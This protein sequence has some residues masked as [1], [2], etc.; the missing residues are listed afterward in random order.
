MTASFPTSVPTVAE[1]KVLVNNLATLLDGAIN[2]A[3]VTI[4]VDDTTGFPTSGYFTIDSEVIYYAGKGATSF[5]SCVRGRDGTAPASHSNNAVVNQFYVADHHNHMAEELI[6][7]CQNLSDRIGLHATRIILQDY[8]NANTKKI[9]SLAAG[10][11]NGDAVRYEQV[12]LLIGGTVT[13]ATIF[14]SATGNP[15]HGTNTNDSASA[16]YI[17]EYVESVVGTTNFPASA[18]AG[19]LTS[20]S[21]SAGDWDVTVCV[22]VTGYNG[23]SFVE[24]GVST[25]SGDSLAGTTAGTDIAVS[26]PAGNYLTTGVSNYRVKISTTTTHYLK[27]Y[28]SYTGS[29]PTAQ[30]IISARRVR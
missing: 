3:V 23:L 19:D 27:Y 10:T 5:T 25:T 12:L 28:A 16:G 6:A 9:S 7:T 2:D 20:V 22:Y 18:I 24:I 17:G 14:S 11:T 4:T 15:I 8:L 29:T 26:G 13:G 21:L 30:G 1:L